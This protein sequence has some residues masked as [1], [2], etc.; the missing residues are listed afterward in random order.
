[1]WGTVLVETSDIVRPL[2][3]C[4]FTNEPCG[5][6]DLC[7]S[8][9]TLCDLHRHGYDLSLSDFA[10]EYGVVKECSHT[11]AGYLVREHLL[12]TK[13]CPFSDKPC[14][15]VKSS[16]DAFKFLRGFAVSHFCRLSVI[17]DCMR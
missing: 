12:H 4:P 13:L 9:F 7:W 10:R 14:V 16:D 2:D 3:V 8:A 17:K 11:T 15:G 1:M 5:V 6:S